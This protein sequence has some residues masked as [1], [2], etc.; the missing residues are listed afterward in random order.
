MVSTPSKQL[1]LSEFLQL[2]ETKPAKEY[3]DGQISQKP[4]PQGKHSTIQ[5]ELTTAI[6]QVLKPEKI[7]RAFPELRCIFGGEAIV[8]DIAVFVWSRIPRDEDN[9]IANVFPLS[10]DWLIEILSPNQSQTK[11]TKKILH[12]LNFETQMSWLI[13]PNEQTVF[14]YLPQQQ[15]QIFDEPNQQIIVPS[16]ANQLQLTIGELFAWLKA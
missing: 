11:I 4:I 1:T 3:I 7:A 16:F 15:I 14:V 5:G 9:S 2:P 12:S 13:D 6:N 8:P 10:P